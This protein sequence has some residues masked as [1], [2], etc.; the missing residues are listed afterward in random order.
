MASNKILRQVVS[1][2]L[3]I[4]IDT[5]LKLC[6]DILTIKLLTVLIV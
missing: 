6:H 3:N 4:L 2:Q 5:T 1:E